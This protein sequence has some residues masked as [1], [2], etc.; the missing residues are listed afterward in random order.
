M[1]IARLTHADK[2]TIADFLETAVREM[3]K[4]VWYP[5]GSAG[6]LV[7]DKDGAVPCWWLNQEID[8]LRLPK[9]DRRVRES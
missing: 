4:R 1:N 6:T 5:S 8:R 3:R 2:L 7:E 9:S